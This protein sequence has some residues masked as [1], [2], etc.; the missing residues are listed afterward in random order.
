LIDER[1]TLEDVCFA[2]SAALD[3]IAVEAVLNRR[4]RGY[5]LRAGGL[6]VVRRRL[7]VAGIAKA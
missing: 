7:R 5:N 3:A 1:S 6:S 4:K 2:V